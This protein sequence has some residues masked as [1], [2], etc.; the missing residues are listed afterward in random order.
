MGAGEALR[1]A[2]LIIRFPPSFA[3]P[4]LQRQVDARQKDA[5]QGKGETGLQSSMLGVYSGKMSPAEWYLAEHPMPSGV[6]RRRSQPS[7][8]WPIQHAPA[9]LLLPRP[10]PSLF[11]RH[12][13]CEPPIRCFLPPIFLFRVLL[14]LLLFLLL[15]LLLLLLV[16]GYRHPPH[17]EAPD[18][19][20]PRGRRHERVGVWCALYSTVAPSDQQHLSG[21]ASRP[22]SA[23]A[24]PLE[25]EGLEGQS[26]PAAGG[27][28]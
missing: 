13:H 8:S 12:P 16:A 9:R 11:Y 25:L 20:H 6:R 19:T 10:P 24:C 28:E 21:M 17:V 7:P 23:S 26:G 1:E 3:D 2:P 4:P 14:P 22:P 5:D 27:R 15:L 18:C